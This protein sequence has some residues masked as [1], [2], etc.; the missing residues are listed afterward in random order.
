MEYVTT[1]H[2]AKKLFTTPYTIRKYIRQGRLKAIKL[3]KHYLIEPDNLDEFV[4]TFT[5][6]T[7]VAGG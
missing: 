3:G 2:A 1:E 4:Q 7:P 6:K 5:Y